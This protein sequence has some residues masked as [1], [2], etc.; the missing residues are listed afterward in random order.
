MGAIGI[1]GSDARRDE[2][3]VL[4][5]YPIKSLLRSCLPVETGVAQGRQKGG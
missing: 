3:R 2:I 4:A 5:L 1:F